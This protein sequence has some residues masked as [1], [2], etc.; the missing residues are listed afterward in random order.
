MRIPDII[1]KKKIGAELSDEEIRYLIDGFTRGDVPDYQMSAFAMAVCFTGMT[2]RE[3]AVLTDAMMRSGETLDLSM[4]GD[5][6]VDKH[7]TGGVGDKTSLVIAP[8]A[9]CLGGIVAKMSG[10]GLGHTGGT[11]DKLESIE[12]FNTTVSPERF[13]SQAREV[14][15]VIA[16]QSANLAPADKKLYG[17]RDVTAT[18][19]SIPL[20]AS[21]I[22]SKKLAAGSHSIVLDVKVGSG[23][24][25]KD[26][27]DAERLAR[28]MVS[29]GSS[30]G[31][32]TRALLTNMDVPLGRAVGNSL[33]VVEAAG[34]LKGEVE[35]DL[36]DVCVAL[37]SNMVSMVNCTD[38][39]E[40]ES[41]VRR[42]IASGEAF[43]KMKEWIAA[44]G[45]N[46]KYLDDISLF[47]RAKHIYEL[48]SD[49]DGYISKTDTEMIG[50]VSSVLGAGRQKAGD[51]IDYSA[52]IEIFAKRGDLV[53]RG[54]V[55]ARFHTSDP[56]LIAPASKEYLGALTFSAEEPER[57]E[58][59]YKVI[60]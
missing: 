13:I 23:A 52:G 50:C 49:R 28:T 31:R 6:T 43:E 55:I 38:I 53:S 24:F 4:F 59:I 22:M 1:Q 40:A 48:K 11:V 60:Q 57:E 45:G 8:I 41:D 58:L 25:M 16:G 46:A 44:Q 15:V 34:V 5:R 19:D 21:S 3:V 10:R 39:A 51:A 12:G 14:G 2:D 37:A 7:S 20:I 42:V 54:D 27:D 33:E 36:K 30:C 56:S 35:G 17:L 9:A 32:R 47:P 26:L 29:I 18:I